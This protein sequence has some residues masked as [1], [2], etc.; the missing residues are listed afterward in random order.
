MDTAGIK[1]S[2]LLL[3]LYFATV[4]TICSLYAAQPIQPVFQ[5]EFGLSG[6][7]AI[8]FTTLMMLPLGFAPLFYGYLLELVPARRVLRGALLALGLLELLFS[9]S[10]GY[11]LL[12][13]LRALQGLLLPAVLTALMSYISYTSGRATVQQ[14]VA[15]YVGMTIIG[16]IL[17]RMLSGICTE[18]FGWRFFFLLLALLFV[19][20]WRLLAPLDPTLR[21]SLT[22]PDPRQLAGLLRRGPLLWVYGAIF[23]IFFAGAALLNFIPFELKRLDG[24]FG[25]AAVGLVYLGNSMGILVA[26]G[27]TRLRRFCGGEI[28]A[29]AAGLAVFMTG[30]ILFLYGHYLV[31]FGAMFVF[32]LGMFAAHATLFGL[33]SRLEEAHKPVANGLYMSFYYFGGAIGSFVPSLVYESWGWRWFIAVLLAAQV[34]A[35]V[36][37]A[38][39]RN[40][41][42]NHGT[43]KMSG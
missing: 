41:I 36:C 23:F 6:L 8:L 31:M 39:L 19:L 9:L 25:E 27:N 29:V 37:V 32:C 42:G 15:V 3:P 16:G 26:F 2:R 1:R 38:A 34:A 35:A 17:G 12:L 24:H 14:A 13:L 20:C 33:V 10:T 18:L 28:G 11:E 5:R 21:L 43:R 7:Q 40:D 4:V 30:T 22:Q